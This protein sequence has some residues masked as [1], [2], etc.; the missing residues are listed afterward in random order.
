VAARALLTA[1]ALVAACVLAALAGCGS[2]P[3]HEP[4]ATTYHALVEVVNDANVRQSVPGNR[5]TYRFRFLVIPGAVFGNPGRTDVLT[6]TAKIGD[7]VVLSESTL[8]DGMQPLAATIDPA[9]SGGGLLVEPAETRFARLA[10]LGNVASGTETV[11]G[12]VF[13]DPST[14]AAVALVYFD[15]PC[16]M[17]GTVGV[18][19]S[20]KAVYDVTIPTA[21]LHWL[22]IGKPEPD[23]YRV[24]LADIEPHTIVLGVRLR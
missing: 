8:L 21:G 9:M 15:R 22:Y 14:R 18:G 10:T 24:E 19:A 4:R 16:R 7:N 5:S 3:A 6:L 11:A 17:S 23:V 13:V 20:R 12:T 2:R 1:C